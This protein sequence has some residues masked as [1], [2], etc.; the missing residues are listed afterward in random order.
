MLTFL[1]RKTL[2]LLLLFWNSASRQHQQQVYAN[3][4]AYLFCVRYSL[5]S[6]GIILGDV[7]GM[8]TQG[9]L[10]GVNNVTDYETPPWFSCGYNFQNCLLLLQ[11]PIYN[12]YCN[13]YCT[14]FYCFNCLFPVS[15]YS[16]Y[17]VFFSLLFA[18]IFCSFCAYF[19]IIFF[20]CS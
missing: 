13:W 17:L 2:I 5:D 16:Q 20:E 14:G 11:Y 4:F 19:F 18:F 8:M 15:T 12:Q 10:Y 7:L 9:C 6:C 1:L 3:H